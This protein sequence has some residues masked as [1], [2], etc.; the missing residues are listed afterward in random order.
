MKKIITIVAIAILLPFS[1]SFAQ[2]QLYIGAGGSVLNTWMTNQNNYGL[3][4][5][6]DYVPTI[7]G[8]GNIHLG[9]DFNQAIGLKL[10]V[11]YQ[12]LGQRYSDTYKDTA[13]TRTL[14]LNYIQLP[15]LFKY[16]TNGEV[17]R[18]YFAIGPQFNFLMSAEQKY[19][20]QGVINTD[21]VYNPINNQRI[22]VGEETVTGNYS[23]FDVMGRLDLGVDISFTPNLFLNVGATL[24]YGFLDVNATSMRIPD[25][26]SGTYSASHNIFGGI[27]IGINYIF[28]M[29][30]KK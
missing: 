22:K 6:M 3:L 14:T 27:N 15:L 24:A 26:S 9:F 7:G 5:E 4:F 19:Y 2:K 29:S 25:Y 28:P 20:K 23:S 21:S 12:M 8:S 30:G 16:R 10:E 11:G 1:A 17:A 18:F 13:Y